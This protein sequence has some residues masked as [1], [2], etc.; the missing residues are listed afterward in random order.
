ML[1]RIALLVLCLAVL[2]GVGGFVAPGISADTTSEYIS[3]YQ[4]N[5]EAYQQH[6]VP[7]VNSFRASYDGSLAHQIVAR[8]IWYME[9][10]YMVYGHSNYVKDGMVD[11]SNFTSL[12]YKDFGINIPSASRSYDSVGVKVPGFY[13]KLQ[14]GSTK[15]YML[16]G[17]ENLKPGDLFTYWKTDSKGERYIAHV[18]I[19]MGLIDGK[20]CIIHTISGRP[21][22]IGITNSF[23]WWYGE[24]LLEARRVLPDSAYVPNKPVIPQTYQLPPQQPV[25][26]P[27]GL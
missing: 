10:G 1:K 14:P 21:T 8:A 23:T 19:Y 3:K 4:N 6:E 2:A 16:V 9:N 15:K 18:A 7:L 11:C 20:P 12:V 24:H 26:M 25:V 5:L 22:A 27:Q 17:V 13:S